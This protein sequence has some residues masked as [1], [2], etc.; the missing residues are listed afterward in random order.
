MFP[1]QALELCSQP[2]VAQQLGRLAPVNSGGEPAQQIN[3]VITRSNSV[4]KAVRAAAA[5]GQDVAAAEQAVL[6]TA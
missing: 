5:C 3:A 4:V 1:Q 6:S 2:Q